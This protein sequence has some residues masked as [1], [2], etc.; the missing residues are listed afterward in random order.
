[1]R[2]RHVMGALACMAVLMPACADAEPDRATPGELPAPAATGTLVARTGMFADDAPRAAQCV[3]VG[4]DAWFVSAGFD[5]GVFV[6]FSPFSV[7]R[8]GIP[9]EFPTPDTMAALLY[10]AGVRNGRIV[11]VGEPIP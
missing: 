4:S 3:F 5:A 1:M 2:M 8:I 9:K 7:Q 10:A 6:P 11:I